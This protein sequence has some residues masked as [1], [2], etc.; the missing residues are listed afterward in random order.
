[1]VEGSVVGRAGHL[2]HAKSSRGEDDDGMIWGEVFKPMGKNR[3]E[4][5]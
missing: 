5:R 4:K 3:T 1:M 2:L